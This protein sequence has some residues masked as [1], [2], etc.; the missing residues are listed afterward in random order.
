MKIEERNLIDISKA[1][2]HK[3]HEEYGI[4]FSQWEG[5]S[6]SKSRHGKHSKYYLC[7]SRDKYNLKCLKEIR[8][9]K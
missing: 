6:R 3:L 2:A 9:N 4:Q 1:E 5:I 8:N 7:D